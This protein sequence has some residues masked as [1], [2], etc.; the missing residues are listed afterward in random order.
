MSIADHYAQS[1]TV[2]RY[3]ESVGSTGAV[4]RTWTTAS[5]VDA[6]IA[7]GGGNESFSDG[8]VTLYASHR[9]YCDAGTDVTNKDRVVYGT[10]TYR[11]IFVKNPNLR[12]HHKQVYLDEVK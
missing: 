1:V 7:P 11:V 12:N 10:A 9:M 3:T 6:L 5:T 8:K 2:E 4:V